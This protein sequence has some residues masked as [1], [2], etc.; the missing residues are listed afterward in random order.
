MILALIRAVASPSVSLSEVLSSGVQID[1]HEAV[2]VV[3]ELMSYLDQKRDGDAGAPAAAP[4]LE[5]V[6]LTSDGTARCDSCAGV[7]D[8]ADIG[9]LLDGMLPTEGKVPGA[10]RYTIARA[11][12]EV[13]APPFVSLEDFASALKRFEK[14]R[15]E[16]VMSAL[17][18]LA[19]VS[20]LKPGRSESPALPTAAQVAS[21]APVTSARPV[22][23]VSPLPPATPLPP[24]TLPPQA[25][26]LPSLPVS[27]A[28]LVPVDRRRNMPSPSRA[29]ETTA[30]SGPRAVR[31]AGSG[32]SQ[33]RAPPPI[34]RERPVVRGRPVIPERPV[35]RNGGPSHAGCRH[36]FR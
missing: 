33:L 15:R 25:A 10:L 18:T 2:A 6:H 28:P 4:T 29:A 5:T 35:Q 22:A 14:G 21:A 1:P 36:R 26:P 23:S 30:R 16:E 24:P 20:Q 13:D 32:G 3:L 11:R 12:L 34:A 27:A 31:S 17:Y 19:S 9:R 8:V 7:P